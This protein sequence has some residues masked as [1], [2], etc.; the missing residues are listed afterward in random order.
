MRRIAISIVLLSF[1]AL[2]SPIGALIVTSGSAQAAITNVYWVDAVY[3][4]SDPLLGNVNAYESGS[5]AVLNVVVENNN[6]DDIDVMG[7]SLDVDWGESYEASSVAS[8]IAE[9]ATRVYEI[10][11]D[12]PSEASAYTTYGWI[13]DVQFEYPEGTVNHYYYTDV[14]DHPLAVYSSAQAN[15]MDSAQRLADRGIPGQLSAKC[16]DLFSQSKAK[17]ALATDQ[18]TS[19]DFDNA[20]SNYDDSLDLLKQSF[21]ADMDQVDLTSDTGNLLKGI[22]ILLFGMGALLYGLRRGGNN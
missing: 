9:G 22:G 7:V 16:R 12:V 17:A 11:F 14:F 18:Y 21:E 1:L 6:D 20:K 8:D 2:V 13:V 10:S 19:G 4:G 15:A 3:Q 5:T